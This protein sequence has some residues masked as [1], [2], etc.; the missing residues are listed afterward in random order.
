M[1]DAAESPHTKRLRL[2][3]AILYF[4]AS[5][6]LIAVGW[7]VH[8]WHLGREIPR[9]NRMIKAA[10]FHFTSPLLDIELPEGLTVYHEPHPFKYKLVDFVKQQTDGVHVLNIAV[11]YRDLADGPWFGI[12]ADAEF[13]PA[14]MM[15][16]PVM[17]AW[18]KRAEKN[19]AE[20]KQSFLFD[21]AVD[22]SAV[23][24]HKPRY[25]LVSGQRYPVETLLE[26]MMSY[27]DNNATS[28]LYTN[29]K[30]EELNAVLD[31]MDTTNRPDDGN[32]AISVH[33]YSGFFRILYNAS[34]LNR[35]MSEKALQLLSREDFP[36]GIT[37]GVPKGTV[38]AAKFG[39]FEGGVRGEEK[40]LHE[41]GIVY[42]PK[43][44]YILGVMTLGSDFVRQ[45]EIIRDI[46]ALVYRE[47]DSGTISDDRRTP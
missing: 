19:P 15:K 8:S 42:H 16:V 25:S 22:M 6:C 41:F 5:I 44:A 9:K 13:N 4:C 33:G 31:G 27:S 2:R 28:L 12:H 30:T 3:Q 34:F 26:Y 24:R 38:V 45:S 32:N 29:L 39:E 47:V 37:A 11:Y 36:E 46:S 10:G 14:S 20:L 35:E 17:I 43:G 1:P 7:Y 40:Q 18:L 21:G 23:Q